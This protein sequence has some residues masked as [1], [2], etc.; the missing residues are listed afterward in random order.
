[1]PKELLGTW[2]QT[3][4]D[5]TAGR[6]KPSVLIVKSEGI[7]YRWFD[8]GKPETHNYPFVKANFDGGN[9]YIVFCG[10]RNST[11]IAVQ[12]YR[13]TFQGDISFVFVDEIVANGNGG[14][15]TFPVGRF[16]RK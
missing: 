16:V 6:E 12:R 13:F 11:N 10:D 8:E 4:D 1:M 14:E 9:V 5:I 7:T 15:G 3:S 2:V